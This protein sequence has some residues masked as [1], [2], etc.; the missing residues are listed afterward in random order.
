[1]TEYDCKNVTYFHLGTHGPK[2]TYERICLI[3]DSEEKYHTQC[4]ILQ[5]LVNKTFLRHCTQV[6]THVRETKH[7]VS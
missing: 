2:Y 7:E 5:I 1:M 6:H 4:K 3:S